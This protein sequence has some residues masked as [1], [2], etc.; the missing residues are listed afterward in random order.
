LWSALPDERTFLPSPAL[1]PLGPS[2]V[3][4]WPYLT[5]SLETKPAFCRL[6]WL[7]E[8]RRCSSPPLHRSDIQY[9]FD[10]CDEATELT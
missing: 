3:N 5:V 6:L 9:L 2:P 8:P 10:T 1:S 4:S 7:S